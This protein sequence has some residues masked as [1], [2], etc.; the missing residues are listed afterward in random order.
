[1]FLMDKIRKAE[2]ED[3]IVISDRCF[4]SSIIYIKMMMIGYLN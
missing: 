2:S 1:M 3:K 4:Y